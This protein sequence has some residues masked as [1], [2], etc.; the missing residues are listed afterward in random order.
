MITFL[1]GGTGTPKLI[2]GARRYLDDSAITVVVNTAE[3]L[4]ISGGHLSP[5]IDT[6][7][8]LFSGRLNT[9]TWWGI[10][11]DTFLTHDELLLMG[12][13]EYIGIGD[14]DRAVQIARGEL[15]KS[16]CTLTEAT[17]I[18]S[19]RMGITAAVLPMTDQ[20]V[21]TLIRTGDRVIHYQEYWVKHRGS[22]P[23]DEVIR[24]SPTG[25]SAT[26]QVLSAIESSDMVIIGPS[27]PVT[28]I[29]PVLECDGIIPALM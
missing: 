4:W 29:L 24:Y 14:R 8:Y 9:G 28:S 6:L 2:R 15:L 18:L 22:L 12:V 16:G 26:G 17:R 1:S 23:I 11:D 3:D 27:N 7:L 13:D 25:P 10:V 21:A 20:Q 19:E 5:D